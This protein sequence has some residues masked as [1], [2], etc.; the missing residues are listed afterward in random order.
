MPI[1]KAMLAAL[2]TLSYPDIDIKKTYK[3]KRQIENLKIRSV[4]DGDKYQIWDRTVKNND[5]DVPVRIFYP[6]DSE[7]DKLII[8]FHGGGWVIGNIDSYTRVCANLAKETNHIVVSVDYRLAPEYK[9]P[10]GL[11]DCYA[12]AK[13]I[14]VKGIFDG[15]KAENI[16][17]MGDSAGGNFTAA[18]SLM[19]R[20][21]KEF[22]VFNQI[23]IYP[24]TGNNYTESSIFDSVRTNG[25]DYLLTSNRVLGYMNLYMNN[26][27]DRK[28]PYFSPLMETDLSDQPRTLII[29]A[30]FCPLRDEGEFYGQLL[31]ENGNNVEIHRMPDALHGYF[32]L[33]PKFKAVKNTYVLVNEFLR[34]R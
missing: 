3:I 33:S 2:K 23:M 8:Y 12:V 29:T 14:Y 28:N 25:K 24:A 9:F 13:E 6:K 31:K 5:Y 1:S 18:I 16:T 30:E 11:E 10:I 34:R 15:I 26:E 21:R 20:D 22:K 17:I 7:Q 19:A 32:S 4:L 27:D